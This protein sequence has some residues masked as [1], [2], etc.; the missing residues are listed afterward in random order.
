[1]TQPLKATHFG[2]IQLGDKGLRCAVLEDNSR[3]ILYS[4]VFDAFDRPVRGRRV[5]NGVVKSELPGFIDA[6]NLK[7][8]IS[9]ELE[10][11]LLNPVTYKAKN[12]RPVKGYKAEII[13]LLCEVYLAARQAEKLTKKQQPLA[14]ASEIL[15]R[16]L[17]KVGIVALVDEATG[18][19]YERERRELHQILSAYI[20]EELLPWT[21]QFPDEFYRH[22]FR[23]RG[24]KYEPSSVK[25]PQYVG[26]LT[27]DL[28]Y[29]QLPEGVAEELKKKTP[30][31]KRL[32]Q[33]LTEDVGNKHL[34]QQLTRV[35]TLMKISSNWKEFMSLFNKVHQNDD[36]TELEI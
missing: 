20:N 1:M 28:V 30:K 21:K 10:D 24:W 34:Q 31:S 33:G 3:V 27:M 26:K 15:V 18:Y 5:I 4:E 2:K 35:I 19:Q 11:M 22:L 13:P 7:P 23:L 9:P 32:H 6:S 8:Y 16:S 12:G 36:Q 25:R 17:S 29:D 14:I